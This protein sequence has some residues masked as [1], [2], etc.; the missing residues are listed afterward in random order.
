MK[1]QVEVQFLAKIEPNREKGKDNFHYG[2]IVTDNDI[3]KSLENEDFKL[4]DFWSKDD[5]PV[6]VGK[7]YLAT[8]KISGEFISF[9]SLD[10][11]L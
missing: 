8:I 10:K 7:K 11:E 3:T 5:L 4:M 1:A 6:M 9:L 2:L